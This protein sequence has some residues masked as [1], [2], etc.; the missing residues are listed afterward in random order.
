M[1]FQNYNTKN[2]AISTLLAG[3]SASATSVQVQS[4]DGV[5]FPT[6]NFVATIIQYTNK[7]DRTSAIVKKEKVLVSTNA[8]DT[9]TITRGF[10]GDTPTAFETG[11]TIVLNVVSE[12]IEDIQDEVARLESDKLNK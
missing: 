11:D 9:F 2:D 10:G 3:I 8:T 5:K 6:G 12:V 7:L 1:T 4:A